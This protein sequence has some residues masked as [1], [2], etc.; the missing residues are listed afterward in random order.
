MMKKHS[1]S[2][3]LKLALTLCL[4]MAISLAGVVLDSTGVSAAV[5]G[6]GTS[7]DPYI[8]TSE[9][10]FSLGDLYSE[11]QDKFTLSNSKKYRLVYGTYEG[12]N[13]SEDDRP[14]WRY[15]TN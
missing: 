6:S 13:S 1:N 7:S 8:F 14:E 10:P 12:F 4:I 2:R 11:V 15:G 3:P 9:Y 5:T